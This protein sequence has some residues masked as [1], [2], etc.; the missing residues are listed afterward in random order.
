MPLYSTPL[1]PHLWESTFTILLS[2]MIGAMSNPSI[3]TFGI[4]A[5][6]A[7][8]LTIVGKRSSVAASCQKCVCDIMLL[9]VKQ[10][11][12]HSFRCTSCVLP[13]VIFPGQR[14]IPGTL[15]PP[16]QVVPLPQRKRPAFPPLISPESAGLA[17][18]DSSY[19]I[20]IWYLCYPLSAVKN[21]NVSLST[22]ASLSAC[23]TCPTPQSSSARASPNGPRRVVLVKSFPANWGWWVCWKAK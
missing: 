4:F 13:G 21:T 23:M 11:T 10:V 1:W 16:S 3:V 5:P 2:R 12:V 7:A 20:K 15:C 6:P 19:T 17:N 22:P 9:H 18:S 14:A 8:R